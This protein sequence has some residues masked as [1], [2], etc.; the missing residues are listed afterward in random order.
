VIY[1]KP[2]LVMLVMTLLLL[3]PVAATQS[4]AAGRS[5]EECQALAVSRG[6]MPRRTEKVFHRYLRYKAAGT[7]L[8][9]KGLVARCMSGTG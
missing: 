5:F 3:A 6:V 7:A 9:P 8:K 1:P 2:L 4:N